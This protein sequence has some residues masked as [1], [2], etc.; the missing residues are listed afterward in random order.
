MYEIQKDL[1]KITFF[2]E[3]KGSTT[4]PDPHFECVK[5]LLSGITVNIINN[6]FKKMKNPSLF[7][8]TVFLFDC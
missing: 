4:K 1:L 7:L 8:S 3:R 5:L 2:W 6:N